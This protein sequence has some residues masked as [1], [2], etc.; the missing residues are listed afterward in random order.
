MKQLVQLQENLDKFEQAGIAVV[1]MTYDAPELQQAFIEKQGIT[2]PFLSDIDA[3]SVIALDILNTE[4]EPGHGAYGIPYPGV[5]VVNPAGEIVGKIFLE[6]YSMRVD[7]DG[8]LAYAK[9]ALNL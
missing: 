6:P 2:Y 9:Q 3:S 8:V 7:A 1:A 5:F 4:Y